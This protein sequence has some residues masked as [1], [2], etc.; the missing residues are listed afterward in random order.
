[1]LD[2]RGNW[3]VNNGSGLLQGA[4][5]AT[6]KHAIAT[7]AEHVA[8]GEDVPAVSRLP[9]DG[10]IVFRDQMDRLIAAMAER[11]M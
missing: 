2:E 8:D 5:V 6:L 11:P 1:M 9:P 3:V 10:I 4:V 7:A